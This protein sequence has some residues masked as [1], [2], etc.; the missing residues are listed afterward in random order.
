MEDKDKKKWI[1]RLEELTKEYNDIVGK[2]CANLGELTRAGFRVPYGFALGL[3]AYEMFMK[4]TGALEEVK[5]Y[6]LS[7]KGDPENTADLS[8]WQEAS[9]VTRGI[10]ESK[11]MPPSMADTI[12]SYYEELC[13]KARI[14]DCPVATR[15]AGAASHPGQYESFLYVRG[16]EEVLRNIIKVWGST[17]NQR[18]LVNRAKGNYSVEYDPIGVV[19]LQMINSKSAGVILTLNP[20]NGDRSVITIEGSFGLGEAVV[21]GKVTP[22]RWMVNKVLLE[23][24]EKY[25]SN[26][27]HFQYTCDSEKK[28]VTI[29]LPSELRNTPCLNEGE[30]K[31]L[32]KI[33]NKIEEHYGCPQDIEWAVDKEI[34]FPE[35]LFIVQ[36]RPETIWS[37]KQQKSVLDKKSSL[38]L[39]MERATTPIKVK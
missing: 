7:F 5:K 38:D 25:I 24:M 30:I 19:V 4:E 26:D 3:D 14:Q 20:S 21:S 27:K 29:E 10:I 9:E 12:L 31:E 36:T 18:S 1:Y 17:L 33:A 8:K 37:K 2:K 11:S 6:F 34:P 22:D 32:A 35:N 16:G 13:G 39:L 28:L 23:I 15:S